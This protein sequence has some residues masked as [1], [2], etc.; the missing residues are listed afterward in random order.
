[1][2]FGEVT[3]AEDDIV[4]HQDAWQILFLRGRKGDY[5]VPGYRYIFFY[6]SNVGAQKKPTVR[7]G[8]DAGKQ[9]YPRRAFT[10]F[11]N[12]RSSESVSSQPIQ[13]SVMLLP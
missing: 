10:A 5:T 11:D 8:L 12:L 2:A 1:M 13:A 4:F 6:I 7:V 3:L 9:D